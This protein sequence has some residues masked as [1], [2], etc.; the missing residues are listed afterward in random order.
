MRSWKKRTEQRLCQRISPG[1]M[2]A[3]GQVWADI[4]EHDESGNVLVGDV[5]TLDINNCYVRANENLIAAIGVN[6][7]VIVATDDAVLVASKDRTQDVKTIV[8]ML[9]DAGRREARAPSRVIRP[10]GWYREIHEGNRH[11]VKEIWV[12]PGQKLSFQLHY[13][14][15]EHWVVVS[16]TARVTKG[17]EVF[18]LTE[19]E[20]TYIPHNTIHSLENPGKIPLRVI[21][22]P[23]WS[24]PRRGR[25]CALSG[26]AWAPTP[27]RS[28]LDNRRFAPFSPKCAAQMPRIAGLDLFIDGYMVNTNPSTEGG[29]SPF[30]A[31]PFG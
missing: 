13:H 17:E 4:S 11:Q 9:E 28:R 27:G 23:V 5:F 26:S 8:G 31:E 18:F 22:V 19:D 15:A 25:H 12:G 21:E 24:L 30:R 29:L 3:L 10:W 20:S 16:G 6:D 7:L 2:L 1:A 14:R